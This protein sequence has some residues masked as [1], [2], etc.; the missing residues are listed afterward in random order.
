MPTIVEGHTLHGVD[1]GVLLF[2][3]LVFTPA[4]RAHVWD[5]VAVRQAIYI[6]QSFDD[7]VGLFSYNTYT[8][9]VYDTELE[10]IELIWKGADGVGFCGDGGGLFG[11]GCHE[12]L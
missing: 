12:L 11:V 5:L 9:F 8:S 1:S 2:V 7:T 10:L 4:V 3:T 6:F